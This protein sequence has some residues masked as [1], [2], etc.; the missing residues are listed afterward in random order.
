MTLRWITHLDTFS[1]NAQLHRLTGG[2]LW[3]G[4]T[5]LAQ[6]T[7]PK[8]PHKTLLLRVQDKP[9]LENWLDDLPMHDQPVFEKWKS[10][11]TLIAR[12]R[13]AISI[14][15]F[16]GP[17]VDATAPLG[18]VVISILQPHSVMAWHSDLGEYA[19]HHL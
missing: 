1:V 17:L 2:D 14:D 13:R 19:K 6:M 18:R 9:S 11:R 15:P 7:D 3:K 16:I 8:M 10:M 12:A 4:K 5:A